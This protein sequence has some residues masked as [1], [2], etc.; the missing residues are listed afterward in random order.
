M[1]GPTTDN[2]D[3]DF[4]LTP[5]D[6]TAIAYIILPLFVFVIGWFE[7]WA[8]VIF[9]V[10]CAYAVRSLFIRRQGSFRVPLTSQQIAI[11][12]VVGC[13]WTV[14]G[15]TDHLLF[16]NADWHIRDAVLH[17][18]VISPWPVGYG[19]HEGKE[20]LLR[21]PLGYYLP[22]ALIGKLTSVPTAHIALLAWTAMGTVLFLMQVISLVENRVS[23]GLLAVGVVILFSGADFVGSLLNWGP[24]FL[25]QWD[26]P[27]HI[28]WWAGS[29]Q[30]SSMTT[31][32]FWVP[33]HA[34]GGWLIIALLYRCDA[35]ADLEPFLPILMVAAAL[36]SPLTAVGLLPFVV[37][38]AGV[39]IFK[40]HSLRLLD[41]RIWLPALLVGLAVSAYLL[42]AAGTVPRGS[43][44]AGMESGDAIMSVLRQMQFF[45]LE[46]GL[47]GLAIFLIRPSTELIVALVVL[48]ILPAVY[49]G[50]GNDLVMRG[51]IPAL[52]V[53]A[54]NAILALLDKT[55]QSNVLRKKAFLVGL[56]LIGAMTPIAEIS[57]ALIFPVWPINVRATLIGA[58]CG[59]FAPHYVANLSGQAITHFLRQPN[60]L[61]LGPLG[62]ESC[63][64]P[65]SYLMW[66]RYP[67]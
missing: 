16:A 7:W 20:T 46:A 45:I 49:L 26:L 56:L 23:A 39:D 3:R 60:R 18:L 52:T 41:P 59:G 22:A 27:M 43:T 47:I 31:Q 11:A 25:M 13:A 15:G 67:I 2:V 5:L 62:P 29:Y 66:R 24:R 55:P 6:R 32:L 58:D 21:A 38:R 34:L 33:N 65:A 14:L 19:L 63:T 42:L 37:W 64:N 50:P 53:L 54:I 36:W 9:V 57:R 40:R 48:A 30:Y 12:V 10:L 1:F 35:T 61:A 17:D 44:L 8:A 28:E 51:S 4:A